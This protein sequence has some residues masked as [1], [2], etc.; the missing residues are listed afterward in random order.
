[1]KEAVFQQCCAVL[2][3]EIH[4]RA[5]K[6]QGPFGKALRTY[7][8]KYQIQIKGNLRILC[9]DCWKGNNGTQRDPGG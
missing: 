4:Q 9:F 6:T 7:L 1:M 2:Q 8:Q 5:D 3:S